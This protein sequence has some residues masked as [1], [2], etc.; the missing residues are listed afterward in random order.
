MTEIEVRLDK[1]EQESRRMKQAVAAGTLVLI[2]AVLMGQASPA[3]EPSDEVRTRRLVVEDSA[4]AGRAILDADNGP[5]LY[6]FDDAGK[7]RV[8]LGVDRVGPSLNLF[9]NAGEIRVGLG[10]GF[11][12]DKD[13]PGLSLSTGKTRF[14]LV[15]GKDGSQL[16]MLDEAGRNRLGLAVGKDGPQLK[17]LDD[18]G[19][20]R[21]GL[22]VDQ[23]NKSGPGLHL[24]DDAGKRRA[25]LGVA[26]S[27]PGLA[28]LDD[29]GI[30]RAWLN[31]L[32]DGPALGLFD[33]ETP[34]RSVSMLS[35]TKTGP[36][37]WIKD[38]LGYSATLGTTTLE[39]PKTGTETKRSAASLV[40]VGQDDKVLW[41]AP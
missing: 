13:V 12:A 19:I 33:A 37:L 40:L 31:L 29:A 2:A 24:Y 11:A 36:H 39:A 32:G 38:R 4:G 16:E 8:G 15:V 20:L 17:M 27:G 35:V 1:L 26:K 28:L 23:D 3:I 7:A 41:E 22:V 14:W 25:I 21:A 6:L 9:D 18:T 34:P 30:N 5:M 10:V